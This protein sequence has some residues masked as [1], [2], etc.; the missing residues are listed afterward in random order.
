MNTKRHSYWLV[1]FSFVM[2]GHWAEHIAQI[3]QIH[4]QGIPPHCAFGMLGKY[5][6]ALVTTEWMHFG[7]AVLTMAGLVFLKY[8]FSG[9][10]RTWWVIAYWIQ[11]WHLFEHI[12]LFGQAQLHHNLFGKAVPTSVFQL[13]FSRPELHLFYNSIVTIPMVIAMIY[14]WRNQSDVQRLASVDVSAARA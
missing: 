5:W 7:Y 3:W 6:P 8:G 14:L 13:V 1:V 4:V 12:L 2:I 11:V 10:A 9:T